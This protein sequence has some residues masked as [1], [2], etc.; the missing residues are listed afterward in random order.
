[1]SSS[2]ILSILLCLI[3]RYP[4]SFCSPGLRL[5]RGWAATWIRSNWP[6]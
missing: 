3:L 4:P 2:E 5:E 6:R 1:M